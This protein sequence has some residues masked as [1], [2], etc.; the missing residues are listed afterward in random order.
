LLHLIYRN[1]FCSTVQL[2][3]LVRGLILINLSVR[4]KRQAK[5]GRRE[6]FLRIRNF[7]VVY[8]AHSVAP[9]MDCQVNGIGII[10]GTLW[11]EKWKIT[12][13]LTLPRPIHVWAIF[14]IHLLTPPSYNISFFLF[15][16]LSNRGECQIRILKTKVS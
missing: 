2:L 3:N 7:T 12:I 1:I 11:N 4:E 5:R 14:G 10:V 13:S 9:T 15:K 16:S 6:S 8:H